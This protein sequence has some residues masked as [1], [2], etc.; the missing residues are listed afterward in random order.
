MIEAVLAPYRQFPTPQIWTASPPL[1]QELDLPIERTY[2]DYWF[3]V[4]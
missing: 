4:Q 3:H 2:I 1:A